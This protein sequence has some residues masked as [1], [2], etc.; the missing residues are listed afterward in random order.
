IMFLIN[1]SFGIP[2]LIPQGIAGLGFGPLLFV[3]N[4]VL[5]AVLAVFLGFG[6]CREKSTLMI[7]MITLNSVYFLTLVIATVT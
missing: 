1:A 5:S 4:L 2:G 7:V 6:I 3:L